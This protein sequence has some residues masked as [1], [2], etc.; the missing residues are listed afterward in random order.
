MASRFVYVI[1]D[2]DQVRNSLGFI[3]QMAGFEPV[4]FE[5]GSDF[6]EK[7]ATLEPGC[8]LLDVRMPG[9]DG[10]YLLDYLIKSGKPWP[11][12]MM[13]GHGDIPL[14]VKALKIG[15]HDF[16]EKPFDDVKLV[17][18]LQ[19]AFT[20]LSDRTVVASQ[21]DEAAT[22]IKALTPREH[23]VLQGL[24]DGL[25]N[26]MIA[27]RLDVG[28]RTIETHRGNM[29][30]KLSA[31]SISDAL[32]TAAVFGF[33]PS[34]DAFTRGSSGQTNFGGTRISAAGCA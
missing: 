11:I 29:M 4:L 34:N 2:D 21:R 14:A 17:A 18:L 24:V 16:L 12:V 5:M 26:K 33:K 15:A 28:V 13:T 8:V 3:L 22:K 1:D 32:Q 10:M 23:D 20:L 9:I 27:R 31:R 25:N 19:S 7:L 30:T 6:L